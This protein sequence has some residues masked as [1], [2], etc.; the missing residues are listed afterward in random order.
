[1]LPRRAAQP[2]AACCPCP[3]LQ[4]QVLQRRAPILQPPL[5]HQELVLDAREEGAVVGVRVQLL[6]HVLQEVRTQLLQLRRV[7][8]R[9]QRIS[10]ARLLLHLLA[11]AAALLL[12]MRG[13]ALAA[14]LGPA[15]GGAARGLCHVRHI[16]QQGLLAD[17]VLEALSQV[18]HCGLPALQLLDLRLAVGG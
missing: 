17:E 2:P 9:H 4:L 3:Y 15:A 13:A 6:A 16:E 12:I 18:V 1:M 11:A 8:R 10:T 14:R 7:L 5:H